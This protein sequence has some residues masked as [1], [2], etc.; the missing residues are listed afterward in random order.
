MID[1]KQI[2]RIVCRH[3]AAAEPGRLRLFA[4]AIGETYSY[5]EAG[6][7]LPLPPTFLFCLEME[8]PDPCDWFA[9]VGL[10]LPKLL[11]GEQRF[12]YHRPCFCG[13]VLTFESRIDD[14]FEKKG[15][16]ME[17]LVKSTR[18]TDESG[19]PV[20][21]LHALIIQRHG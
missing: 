20:A 19:A 6:E 13:D 14:V 17:F 2:G 1:R 5:W 4:K 16:L 7:R 21:D 18:V 12:A 11:H 9:S 10:E 8:R 15:G 3:R